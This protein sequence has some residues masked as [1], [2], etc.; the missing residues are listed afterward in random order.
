MPGI[1]SSTWLSSVVE[2]Q[3]KTVSVSYKHCAA[4]EDQKYTDFS[5]YNLK[6][7]ASF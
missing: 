1:Y 7:E 5:K 6:I 2:R 3:G 4:Q